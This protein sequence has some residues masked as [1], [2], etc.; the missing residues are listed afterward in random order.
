M[1]DINHNNKIIVVIK[2]FA[3]T[4][5]DKMWRIIEIECTDWE[6][7]TLFKGNNY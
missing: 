6:S 2:S 5:Y 7:N 4:M 1:H 3:K